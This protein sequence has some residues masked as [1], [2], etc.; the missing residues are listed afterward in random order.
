[1]ILVCQDFPVAGMLMA[2]EPCRVRDLRPFSGRGWQAV[3]KGGEPGLRSVNVPFRPP[4]LGRMTALAPWAE[5]LAH[6]LIQ[7]SVPRRW[8]HV[9][10]VAARARSLAPVLE[11]DADLL[12]AAGWLHDIGYVPGPTVTGL[13]CCELHHPDLDYLGL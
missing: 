6:T 1:M 3:D 7:D 5:H 2:R 9:Q 12:E 13:Y 11:A 8:A 10:G 4:S